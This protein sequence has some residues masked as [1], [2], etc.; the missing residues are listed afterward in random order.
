MPR[1]IVDLYDY[2]WSSNQPRSVALWK[3]MPPCLFWCLWRE[4]NDRNFEDRE[5]A[6]EILSLFYETLYLWTAALVSPL[7][8]TYSDFLVC[9][10]LSS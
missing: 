1:R 7:L 3:M 2:W 8:I 4:M 10:G 5:D 6:G 9:F